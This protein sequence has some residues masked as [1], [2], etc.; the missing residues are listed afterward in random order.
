[1]SLSLSSKSMTSTSR[2]RATGIM[3]FGVGEGV[4][5]CAWSYQYVTVSAW[6]SVSHVTVKVR[7]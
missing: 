4:L 6:G 1:V 3:R 2:T 7:V 5:G